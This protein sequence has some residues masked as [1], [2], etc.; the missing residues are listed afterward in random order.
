VLQNYSGTPNGQR[1]PTFFSLDAEAYR[2]FHL[3]LPF[4]GRG[5]RHKVRIGLYSINLT[6]H[7]NFHDVYNNVSSPFFGQVTGFQ[8]RVNGFI[9]SFAD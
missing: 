8:R 3:H 4:L 1:F 7:G 2:D 6:N 9:L 5:S